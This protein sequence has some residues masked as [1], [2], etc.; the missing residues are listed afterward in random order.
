VWTAARVCA[1]I[2]R[3]QAPGLFEQVAD[4]LERDPDPPLADQL[5]LAAAVSGR[6]L[7]YLSG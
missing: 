3:A 2:A 5:R 7:A 6:L 1:G 4:E